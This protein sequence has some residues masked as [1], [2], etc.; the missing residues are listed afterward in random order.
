MHLEFQA[1]SHVCHPEFT[2]NL[3]L[4]IVFL[5]AFIFLSKGGVAINVSCNPALFQTWPALTGA[6]FSAGGSQYEFA[7]AVS[8]PLSHHFAFHCTISSSRT[9]LSSSV[10]MV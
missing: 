7:R 2:R 8:G 9:L 6:G 4:A 5:V 1:P 3:G 10:L